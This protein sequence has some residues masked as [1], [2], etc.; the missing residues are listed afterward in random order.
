M[1]KEV[2]E[3]Q[4]FLIVLALGVAGIFLAQHLSTNEA[5]AAQEYVDALD[6]GEKLPRDNLS[7]KDVVKDLLSKIKSLEREK[8]VQN[9]KL[10]SLHQSIAIDR[11]QTKFL[12]SKINA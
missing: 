8:I 2:T 1:A 3:N 6:N 7:M 10:S 12:T 9:D 11:E 5:R 4:T